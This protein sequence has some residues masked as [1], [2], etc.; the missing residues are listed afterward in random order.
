[1]PSSAAWNF[2]ATSCETGSSR[3]AEKLPVGKT[4]GATEGCPEGAELVASGVSA[5]LGTAVD[6]KLPHPE[7]I[8]ITSAV[9]SKRFIVFSRRGLIQPE[10]S[11]A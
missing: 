4:A 2:A 11:W 8:P 9:A 6:P 1:M 10:P 3:S 7:T 5:G